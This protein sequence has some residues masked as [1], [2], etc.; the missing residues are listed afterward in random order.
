V[1]EALRNCPHLRLL[2]ANVGVSMLF[3]S[4]LER[5]PSY[6]P[7]HNQSYFIFK[8]KIASFNTL[9]FDYTLITNLMH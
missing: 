8:F 7:P 6:V 5:P 9:R 1:I 4:K 3:L 2:Q